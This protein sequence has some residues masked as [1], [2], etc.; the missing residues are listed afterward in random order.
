MNEIF[1]FSFLN[2]EIVLFVIKSLGKL[3]REFYHGKSMFHGL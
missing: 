2:Y 1:S 3:G